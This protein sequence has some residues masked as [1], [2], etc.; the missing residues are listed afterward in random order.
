[1]HIRDNN[2]REALVR[3]GGRTGSDLGV[4]LN[5]KMIRG[6]LT[7]GTQG[8]NSDDDEREVVVRFGGCTGSDL[9]MDLN[10]ED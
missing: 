7:T 3:F 2:E 1:L 8:L 5:G 6:S 4:D 10:G 9:G